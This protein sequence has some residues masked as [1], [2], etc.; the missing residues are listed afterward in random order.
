MGSAFDVEL[1]TRHLT[2]EQRRELVCVSFGW[3][4]LV[5]HWP[6]EECDIQAPHRIESCGR[7][8]HTEEPDASTVAPDRPGQE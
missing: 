8:D 5:C 7:F 2:D 3:P 4:D 6:H 1:F